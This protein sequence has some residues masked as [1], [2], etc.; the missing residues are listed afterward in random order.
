M[1]SFKDMFTEITTSA[2]VPADGFKIPD[3]VVRAWKA[4]LD[5]DRKMKRKFSYF[6]VAFKSKTMT[7]GHK[8]H[9]T[10]AQNKL[11]T[12]IKANNMDV[13]ATIKQLYKLHPPKHF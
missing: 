2:A 4:S 9:M 8:G 7:P 5:Y 3:C 13:N 6:D 11:V 10:R 12:T 1:R